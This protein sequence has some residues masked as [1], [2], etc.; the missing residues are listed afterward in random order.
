MFYARKEEVREEDGK[1]VTVMSRVLEIERQ[2]WKRSLRSSSKERMLD[3][4]DHWR[5]LCK[6]SKYRGCCLKTSA[7]AAS[8]GRFLA[9]VCFSSK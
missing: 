6:G 8:K 2:T 1:F 3:D 5:L 4:G 9:V 7:P